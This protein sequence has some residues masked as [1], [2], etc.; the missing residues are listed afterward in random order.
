MSSTPSFEEFV[1]R[2]SGLLMA[3]QQE[4]IRG[5][6]EDLANYDSLGKISVT[7]LIEDLFGCSLSQDDLSACSTAHELYD[8]ASSK[9]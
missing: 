8:L 7:V 3:S 1:G 9:E 6:L 4:V 2:L 5:S